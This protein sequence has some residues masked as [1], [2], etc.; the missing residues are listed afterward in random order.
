VFV[1]TYEHLIDGKGRLVLPS[2]FRNKL[3]DG[4]YLGPVGVSSGLGLWPPDAFSR[5]LERMAEQVRSGQTDANAVRGITYNSEEV[6]PD[7]QGR[8]LLSPRLREWA[9]L[10]SEVVVLGAM[11]HIEIWNRATWL[12]QR[13]ALARSATEALAAGHGI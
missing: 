9:G 2:K 8:I 12:D 11:D 5:M 1:G 7:A 13:D 10:G 6:T 4:G 3:P